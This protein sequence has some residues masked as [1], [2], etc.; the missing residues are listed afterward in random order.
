V[1]TKPTPEAAGNEVE[2]LDTYIKQLK[3][4]EADQ[5]ELFEAA[6]DFLRMKIEKIEWARRG[7]VTAQSF[8]DY[9]DALC[10]TWK[11]QTTLIGLSYKNNPVSYG[12]AVYAQCRI[13]SG[14]Q[15]LQG[16]ETPY[17]FG[18]G[19][20]QGLANDP[21]DSPRIWWHPQYID[22]LRRGKQ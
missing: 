15:K 2:R 11:D 14:K 22:L 18:S 5:T 8:D 13:D 10:R 4:I 3:L 20:L 12:K 16:S 9:H 19:S 21:V 7:L 6:S 17:F 1:S